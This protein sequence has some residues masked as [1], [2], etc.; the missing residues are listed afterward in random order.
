MYTWFPCV[1]GASAPCLA[2]SLLY[3]GTPVLPTRIDTIETLEDLLSE[4]TSGLVDATRGHRRH[5]RARRRRQDGPDARAHGAA[6]VRRGRAVTRRVIGVSRFHQPPH[7][8]ASRGAGVETIRCD[9]L[10]EAA[11]W[12]LPD[13]PNVVFMAGRKFG[14][15]GGESLTW[16]MNCLCPRSSAAA[17]PPAAS[18][19]SRPATCIASRPR[20]RGSRE[21]RSPAPVGEYAMSCLGRERMFEHFSRHA[22]STPVTILRLNYAVEMRYG[23]LVDLARKFCAGEP[24][25]LAMGYFNVIWQGDANAMALVALDHAAVAAVRPQRRRAGGTQRARRVSRSSRALMDTSRRRSPGTEA[26]DA[27]LSNGRVAGAL[28]P[29]ARGCVAQLIEL[30]RRLGHHA[31]ARARQADAFRV[32]DGKF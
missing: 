21:T 9:L 17:T 27:L 5:H 29:P 7:E 32:R 13:A 24:I 26:G 19:P 6:R 23:V 11:V 28:R 3:T 1:R 31:A 18:S 30:D 10:D 20:A 4:P 22:A 25:D 12:R 16:A 8:A 15:T 2:L 14:S